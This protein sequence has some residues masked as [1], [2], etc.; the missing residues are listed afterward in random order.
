M[1]Q[2]NTETEIRV[3]SF[4]IHKNP[5]VLLKVKG[6]AVLVALCLSLFCK[7]IASFLSASQGCWQ[8]QPGSWI[9]P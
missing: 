1:D 4:A 3:F 6:L 7:R 9:L 2:Q 8:P 5:T